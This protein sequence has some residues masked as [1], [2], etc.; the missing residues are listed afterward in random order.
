[1]AATSKD[2]VPTKIGE[3]VIQMSILDLQGMDTLDYQDGV[4]G[5]WF[6]VVGCTGGSAL[7]ISC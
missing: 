1:V 3:E 5:S 7:S 2:L 6:S 4:N